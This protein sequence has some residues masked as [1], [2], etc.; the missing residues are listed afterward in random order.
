[1]IYPTQEDIIYLAGIVDGEGSIGIDVGKPRGRM[2]SPNHFLRLQISNTYA[3]LIRWIEARFGGRATPQRGLRLR[4]C[5]Q[6]VEHGQA[7]VDLLRRIQ[8]YLI[9]KQQQT[10]LA[11]EFWAQRT[12]D[13]G[14]QTSEEELALRE[15]FRL[16][17]HVANAGEAS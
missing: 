4:T 3:P 1:V 17:M 2:R 12:S 16:A 15:S 14:H 7:A 9:V 6:W 8:P 11:L 10:R 5:W 13:R